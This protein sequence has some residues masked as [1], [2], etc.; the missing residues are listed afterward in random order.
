MTDAASLLKTLT[1]R[2]DPEALALAMAQQPD[3]ADGA[4]AKAFVGALG[5]AIELGMSNRNARIDVQCVRQ[6]FKLK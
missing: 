1:D 3:K 6:A 2:A 4:K 5:K